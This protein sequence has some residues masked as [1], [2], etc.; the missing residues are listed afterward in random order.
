MYFSRIFEKS[1]AD[2]NKLKLVFTL[3][4]STQGRDTVFLLRIL[5]LPFLTFKELADILYFFYVTTVSKDIL[6]NKY[7]WLFPYY[8]KNVVSTFRL[9]SFTFFHSK[10]EHFNIFSL[11]LQL[12]LST[13]KFAILLETFLHFLKISQYRHYETVKIGTNL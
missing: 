3:L 1:L 9:F 13:I 6:V 2:Q 4:R 8:K 5:Y 12:S 11:L 10:N 7:I